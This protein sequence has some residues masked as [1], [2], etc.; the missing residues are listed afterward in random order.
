MFEASSLTRNTTAAATS[1]GVPARREGYVA[2]IGA[3]RS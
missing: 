2:I 3:I 1:S